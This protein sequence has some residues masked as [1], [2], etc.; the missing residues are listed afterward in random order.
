MGRADWV[1]RPSMEHVLAALMPTNRLVMECCIATGLRVGDVLAL[2]SEVLQRSQRCTVKEQKT[3][4]TRRIYWPR[5]LY[6]RMV[7]QAG[8]VWV[9]EGRN[10]WRK[11]RTRS[12]VYKDLCRAAHVFRVSGVLSRGVQ[13]T[14]HSG[15]KIWA[16]N[17]YRRT[18][19]LSA[20][21][22]GL[23]HDTGHRETTMLYA[24]ADAI[25]TEKSRKGGRKR[26]R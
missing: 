12:A 21:G 3:G 6:G 24:L 25:T 20:V 14:T 8:R 1:D 2:K 17:E 9:F 23:N 4:K 13:V 19:D 15:R 7:A 10:D 22:A 5:E 16:V 11:H 18:G 26:R